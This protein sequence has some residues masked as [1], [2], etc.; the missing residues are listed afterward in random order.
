MRDV[1]FV[2]AWTTL[3]Q[4]ADTETLARTLVEERLAACVSTQIQVRSVYRW[5]GAIEDEREQ[6]LI[7]KTTTARVNKLQERVQQL[8]PYEVPE[9]VVLPVIAGN[10]AYLDWIKVST[11]A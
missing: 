4:D 8:H 11:T 10:A 1:E 2:I 5:Q 9:F 6:L 3:P 7:M